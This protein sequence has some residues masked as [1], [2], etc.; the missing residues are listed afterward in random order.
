MSFLPYMHGALTALC[1]VVALFFLRLWSR[2]RDRFYLFFS[3]AF[4]VMSAQWAVLGS[5]QIPEH[6]VWPYMTRLVAFLVIL[7]AI[8]D[9]NRRAARS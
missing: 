7:V 2:S 5:N 6:A 1:L 9:K 8:V 3:I 4:G